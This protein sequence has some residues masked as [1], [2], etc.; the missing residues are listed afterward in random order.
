[1]KIKKGDNVV[2]ITGKDR[3]ETGKILRVLPKEKK[4]V[5]E[6]A[7][8][9]KKR[10]RPEKRGEKGKTVSV[11]RAIPVSNVKLVCPNCKKGVR[12]GYEVEDDGKVR[13]CKS[14]GN[15]I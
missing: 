12:V 7:N 6:D 15:P 13:I 2:I 1:M 8:L 5:V 11:P 9:V 3:G 10:M 14:C 4:V